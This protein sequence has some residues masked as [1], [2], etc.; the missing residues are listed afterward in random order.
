[1]DQRTID[2]LNIGQ[3][4]FYILAAKDLDTAVGSQKTI[5]LGRLK[6]LNPVVVP[7]R[8]IYSAIRRS[9]GQINDN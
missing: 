9:V 4:R 5:S 7:Y 8:D 3:W 6:E 1:M 2:P